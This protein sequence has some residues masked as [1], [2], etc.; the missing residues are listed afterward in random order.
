MIIIIKTIYQM[1]KL[2]VIF[3]SALSLTVFAQQKQVAMLEP[4]AVAG[5]VKPIEK[6]MIRG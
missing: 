6:S 3:L 1:R 4:V 5:D 2:L